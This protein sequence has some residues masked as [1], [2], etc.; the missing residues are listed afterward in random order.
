MTEINTCNLCTYIGHVVGKGQVR[1]MKAKVKAVK[2][3]KQ[4]KTK[5]DVQAFLG[6][7]GYYR[8]FSNFLNFSHTLIEF[9]PEGNAKQSYLERA[10][11]DII[12]GEHADKLPG[13]EYTHLGKGIHTPNRCLK[14][15][16][17]LCHKSLRR[18]GRRTPHCLWL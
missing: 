10:V 7:C 8:R 16:Y 14:F 1:P 3:F 15:W 2:E 5:K 9:D 12:S 6:L 11:G 17:W 4:P 18:H 13:T